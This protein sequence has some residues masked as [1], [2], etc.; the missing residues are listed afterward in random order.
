[1]LYAL[2]RFAGG[3]FA[4]PLL[5][6]HRNSGLHVLLNPLKQLALPVNGLMLLQRDVC[7]LSLIHI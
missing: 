1:M 2:P 7:D 6:S 3:E 5:P 4:L